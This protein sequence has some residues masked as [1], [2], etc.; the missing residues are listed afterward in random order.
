MWTSHWTDDVIYERLFHKDYKG[1]QKTHGHCYTSSTALRTAPSFPVYTDHGHYYSD[2]E[3]GQVRAS[4]KPLE[5]VEKLR[6]YES[7]MFET[8][9]QIL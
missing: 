8:I 2:L 1:S 4:S 5:H 9:I 3:L 7:R 6:K